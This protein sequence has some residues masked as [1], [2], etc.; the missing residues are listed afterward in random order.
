MSDG[1]V[2]RLRAQVGRLAGVRVLVVGDVMLDR[3][4]RGRVERIS[5]EAP[6]P[7][8]HV[9]GEDAHA[10]GAG[11]VAAH[12]LRLRGRP[13]ARVGRAQAGRDLRDVLRGLGVRTDGLV[14][15]RGSATTQKTRIVAHHQQV[16][17]LDHEDVG[18]V[19]VAAGRRLRD[20][21]LSALRR[22]D[23]L[24]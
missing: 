15:G 5:P 14:A 2:R 16:V 11:N 9:T 12:A 17:R 22:Y 10:G 6:V 19:D 13:G 3:F 21:V 24:V 1:S 8:V 23:V 20:W 7:V 4:V 18:T